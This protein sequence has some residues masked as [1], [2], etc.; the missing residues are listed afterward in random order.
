MRVKLFWKNEPMKLNTGVFGLQLSRQNACEV[1]S[2]INSWLTDNTKI[3]L[4]KIHLSAMSRVVSITSA[5]IVFTLLRVSPADAGRLFVDPIYG[6]SI[7][8]NITYA[9]GN[10]TGTSIPLKLDIYS[11]TNIGQGA[12]PHL[13]PAV[14]LQDGGAWTSASKEHERVTT[15][16]TYL[17]QR[18]FT[19]VTANYRQINDNPV[20]GPG[21]WNSLNFPF[22]IQLYPSANVVRA[23][24]EDFAKAMEWTRA[25]A[26][27]YGID[28]SRIAAA[29]G[30][31]GG[32]NALLL[33]YN[34]PSAAYSPQA[35]IALVATMYG[36]HTTINSGDPPAFLLNSTTDPLVLYSPDVPNMVNRMNSEGVYNEPWIHDL[37]V[38]VHDV[39][40]NYDLDGKSVLERMREFLV[41]I[42][43]P[44]L[45]GDYDNDFSVDAAD[46]VAWRESDG[47]LQ[48]YNLRRANFGMTLS[49]GSISNVSV[50][51]PTSGSLSFLAIVAISWMEY[52]YHSQS[53]R[54]R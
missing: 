48:G 1:E 16:A 37:G 36:N 18:G 24:I 28:A 54:S 46:Y 38:G 9:F 3:T 31:A 40:Y 13:S 34:N 23:G 14:V 49:T 2:E 42:F 52:R 32:I 27:T 4:V 5:F 41:S 15:P 25:N 26:V 45:A 43:V 33:T 21:P 19:V 20:A 17:A 44:P 50:P 22:Y 8:S 11:P 53:Q 12:V 47:S 30:S 39:D 35:V 29:G 51:E 10:T 6:V 7:T